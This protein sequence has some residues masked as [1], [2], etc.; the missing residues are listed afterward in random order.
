VRGHVFLPA[1]NLPARFANVALQPV[2]RKPIERRGSVGQEIFQPRIL[3]MELGADSGRNFFANVAY[4]HLKDFRN[5][6]GK[7]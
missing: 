7:V 4:R 6:P 1:G 3:P 5:R 2:D